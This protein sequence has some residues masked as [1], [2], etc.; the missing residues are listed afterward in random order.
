[1]QKNKNIFA[2]SFANLKS[3]HCLTVTAL[4][5]ALNVTLDLLNIR[6]QLTPELRITFGFLCNAVI[7]MLY[8]PSVGM[9]AGFCTDVLGY[10]VNTGGGA[11]FPGYTLTAVAGGLIY[12]LWLYPRKPSIPRVLGAKACINLF[13]NVGLNT[14]WLSLMGGKAMELLLPARALK[15]LMMWPLEAAMLYFVCRFALAA[16]RRISG[17]KA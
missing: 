15:N 2:E 13:C 3:V 14:L 4:F 1:M 17:Q 10:M 11:Y 12:G 9:T 5:I 6:V 16:Q 8:G 7:A